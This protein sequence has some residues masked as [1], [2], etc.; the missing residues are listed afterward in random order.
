MKLTI[1]RGERFITVG[2][3]GQAY[4]WRVHRD[5]RIRLEHEND[6]RLGGDGKPFVRE[7]L[8]LS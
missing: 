2:E 8:R 4:I 1:R 7:D 5:G 6:P 3:D